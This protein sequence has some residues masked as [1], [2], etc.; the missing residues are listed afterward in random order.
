M[1]PMKTSSKALVIEA[2]PSQAQARDQERSQNRLQTMGRT[3]AINFTAHRGQHVVGIDGHG[4]EELVVA[5][6][7]A[8]VE[9]KFRVGG[10]EENQTQ[11]DA[12]NHEQ[13]S[14]PCSRAWRGL[15]GNRGG[16]HDYWRSR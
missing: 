16:G 1:A 10:Y 7:P 3:R 14:R 11:S 9:M 15:G 8:A 4:E 2:D 12:P 13:D 6:M 5:K